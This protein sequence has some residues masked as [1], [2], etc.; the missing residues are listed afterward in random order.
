MVVVVVLVARI[1]KADLAF[2][3]ARQTINMGCPLSQCL[4]LELKPF[5]WRLWGALRTSILYRLQFVTCEGI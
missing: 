5:D 3:M 2:P 1:K 4:A